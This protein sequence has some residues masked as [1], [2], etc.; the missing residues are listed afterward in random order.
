MTPEENIGKFNSRHFQ[1]N[2]YHMEC[3]TEE[4]ENQERLDQVCTWITD[5]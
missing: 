1:R 4:T 2:Q 3:G 5:T